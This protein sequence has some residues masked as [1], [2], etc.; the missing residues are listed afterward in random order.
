M[1]CVFN[2]VCEQFIYH[3]C[4]V[5]VRM[6]FFNILI[7]VHTIFQENTQFC[8]LESSQ[9]NY[10]GKQVWCTPTSYVFISVLVLRENYISC[11]LEEAA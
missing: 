7:C 9:R 10:C 4:N 11:M 8:D 2:I 5:S 6:V 3:Q 1:F